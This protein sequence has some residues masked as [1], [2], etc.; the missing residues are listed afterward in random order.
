[1]EGKRLEFLSFIYGKPDV[2]T[3]V[4]KNNNNYS[5][6]LAV[7]CFVDLS[8]LDFKCYRHSLKTSFDMD[9]IASN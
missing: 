3:A 5:A 1:M 7:H 4:N 2:T 8:R 9:V 6:E